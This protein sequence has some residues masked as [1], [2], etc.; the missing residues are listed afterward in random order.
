MSLLVM[1]LIAL[2]VIGVVGF[3]IAV[4]LR[5]VVPTNEVHVVQ[6]GTKT[7]SYVRNSTNGNTYYQFP[8]WIPKIGI[9]YVSLPLSVFDIDLRSYE[10]YD[11]G[12]VPFVVDIKAFFR[13]SDP[14]K[15]AERV[16]SLSEL[17]GQLEAILQGATRTILASNEIEEIMQGRAKYGQQFTDEVDEQLKE[18]GVCT[19]KS[20]ELMDIRD[21]NGSEVIQNIMEKK[22]SLIDMQSRTEVSRNQKDANVA[23]IENQRLAEI[24]KQEAIQSVGIR[25]AEQD[26]AVGIAQELAQQEI[27]EAAKVTAEKDMAVRQVE[28][29]RASEIE[30]DVQVVQAEE[31]KAT[32]VISAEGDKQKAVLDA[33]A[34]LVTVSKEAEGLLVTAQNDAKGIQAIGESKANAEQLMQMA[35]VDPQITLATEIGENEGYQKY[36]L[37]VRTIEREEVVGV[38]QAQALKSA[39]LKVI[40]NTGSV[41]AGV[42]SLSDVLKSGSGGM[43]AG[44]AIEA[45]A[46]T[47]AG[48]AVLKKFGINLDTIKDAL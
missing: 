18:W 6:S 8:S 28:L 2:G 47:E 40:A 32:S 3:I 41:S 27:K 11:Q 9:E 39:D 16:S 21:S 15:A 4:M 30:K 25:T 1:G 10:A 23:E 17:G 20:I 5:E 33:E 24:A 37:G 12:R 46:L 22:Q 42:N 44:A 19:V 36:L 34:Q 45:F 13:I 26:Q 14:N 29:V 7:I 48:G 35:H 38:E 43:S 31:H